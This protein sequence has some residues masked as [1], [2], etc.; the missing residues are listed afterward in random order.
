M[1]DQKN[2]LKSLIKGDPALSREIEEYIKK[3]QINEEKKKDQ[4]EAEAHGL[5]ARQLTDQDISDYKDFIQ[6]E[7][8]EDQK[9]DT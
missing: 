4:E 1:Q 8:E 2:Y 7:K 9:E 5:E 6:E 3:R